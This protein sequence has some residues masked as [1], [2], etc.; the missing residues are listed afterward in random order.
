MIRN[1]PSHIS[2]LLAIGLGTYLT[3]FGFG[4]W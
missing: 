1:I 2:G 4:W 3:G